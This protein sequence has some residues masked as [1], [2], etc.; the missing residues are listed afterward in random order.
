TLGLGGGTSLAETNRASVA[1]AGGDAIP[2]DASGAALSG[3]S[4]NDALGSIDQSL[5][6]FTG[7][8]TSAA[9]A[10]ADTVTLYNPSSLARQG[11]VTLNDPNPLS[12]LS[13]SFRPG[14]AGVALV[15]VQG[16]TQSFKARTARGLVFNGE[17]N[18]NLVQIDRATDTTIV[19]YPFG[20]AVIPNRTNVTILSTA[21][22]V[23]TRND[24]TVPANLR[25]TGPLSLPTP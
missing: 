23:G 9:G 17:G 21:R 2:T 16:F 14:L 10:K 20:H 6:L 1:G 25:P 3:S 15:D 12:G 7:Q 24:V 4:L 8:T 5:A 13:G 19:G 22:T 18:V 11:T